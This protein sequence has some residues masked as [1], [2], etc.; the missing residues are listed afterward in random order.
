[1]ILTIV[2]VIQFLDVELTENVKNLDIFPYLGK[3][4][5]WA[6]PKFCFS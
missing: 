4:N 6:T 5:N 1:M 3:K 2:P